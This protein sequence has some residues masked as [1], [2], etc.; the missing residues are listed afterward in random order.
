LGESRFAAKNPPHLASTKKSD[1]VSG[2]HPS[3]QQLERRPVSMDQ[4]TER[5]FDYFPSPEGDDDYERI[6]YLFF[7]CS[8]AVEK[9]PRF[10]FPAE[11]VIRAPCRRTNPEVREGRPSAAETV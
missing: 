6:A 2:S 11:L 4:M 7:Y 10:Q 1:S 5:G 8:V 3:D 9:W